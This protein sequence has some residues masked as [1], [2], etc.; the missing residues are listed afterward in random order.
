MSTR[1]SQL[2]RL[3]RAGQLRMDFVSRLAQVRPQA[4]EGLEEALER[5]FPGRPLSEQELYEEF[6]RLFPPDHLK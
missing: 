1:A 2:R 4:P 3:E 6:N 5:T